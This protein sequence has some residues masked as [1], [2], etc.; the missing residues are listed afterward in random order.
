MTSLHQIAAHAH[1]VR[2]VAR[3][4]FGTSVGFDESGVRWLDDYVA[5]LGVTT[6]QACDGLVPTLACF[7]GEAIVQSHAGA[8]APVN[9]QWVV[10]LG[11]SRA[12]DPFSKVRSTLIAGRTSQFLSYFNGFAPSTSQRGVRR[13]GS[14]PQAAS[15][16]LSGPV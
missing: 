15:A 16:Q 10:R 5:R 13:R 14:R 8:W 11:A 3:A 9:E 7:L 4:E 1:R 2:L 12:A 6:G